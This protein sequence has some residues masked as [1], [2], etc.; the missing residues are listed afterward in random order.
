MSDDYKDEIINKNERINSIEV[1]H[2]SDDEEETLENI[3]EDEDEVTMNFDFTID[4]CNLMESMTSPYSDIKGRYPFG[5]PE[6]SFSFLNTFVQ[7][8]RKGGPESIEL[9]EAILSSSENN[10]SNLINAGIMSDTLISHLPDSFGAIIFLLKHKDNQ[11][12]AKN[13]FINSNGIYYL[14]KLSDIEECQIPILKVLKQIGPNFKGYTDVF[15][16]TETA[17]DLISGESGEDFEELTFSMLI[18]NIFSS[19]KLEIIV[20]FLKVLNVL[21]MHSSQAVSCIG[22]MFLDRLEE[23][24]SEPEFKLHVLEILRNGFDNGLHSIMYQFEGRP[25]VATEMKILMETLEDDEAPEEAT[26]AVID[27]I[28][29]II[30][31]QY[32]SLKGRTLMNLISQEVLDRIAYY[33]KEGT[34]RIK[35]ET[36]NAFSTIVKSRN[37]HKS[38][39]RILRDTGAVGIVSD[40]I[41]ANQEENLEKA[42]HLL[43]HF[44]MESSGTEDIAEDDGI[45]LLDIM[46]MLEDMVNSPNRINA[47]TAITIVD[48]VNK[49]MKDNELIEEE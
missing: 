21:F 32:D 24:F 23:L 28:A 4:V 34:F 14:I 48:T 10:I 1:D 42:I 15:Y 31:E 30:H 40:F 49:W 22:I 17:F 26:T 25:Y 39:L 18:D 41:S 9:L 44:I 13:H 7:Y 16:P 37:F 33:G 36:V 38:D 35:K 11:N 47:V 12:N 5:I 43:G 29:N 20:K 19:D 27:I 6:L 45:R 46:E 8:F 2:G 3:E